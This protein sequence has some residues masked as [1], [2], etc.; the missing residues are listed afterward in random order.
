MK[1]DFQCDCVFHIKRKQSLKFY[2]FVFSTRKI[3]TF[4]MWKKLHLLSFAKKM[5]KQ[6]KTLLTL[7]I[8]DDVLLRKIAD[9]LLEG[10]LFCITLK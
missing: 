10:I 8:I 1:S 2:L 6:F 4:K 5:S 7:L 3:A 9:I